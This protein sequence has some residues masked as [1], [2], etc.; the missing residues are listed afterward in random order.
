MS[1]ALANRTR[2]AS[3][4]RLR[5]G[6]RAKKVLLI[7]CAVSLAPLLPLAVLRFVPPPITP[8]MIIRAHDGYRIERQWVS[9]RAI[10]QPLRRAAI[11]AE[12]N[13]FC[14]ETSGIDFDALDQAVGVWFEG[15]RPH[16]ASTITMQTARNL[17]LWPGR[18]Y[19]RKLIELWITPQ[20]AI[21]WP[22]QR[23][24]E[25]YLNI[26]EFGPAIFGVQAAARHYFGKDASQLSVIEATRLIAVLPD[27]LHR[28]PATLAPH[29]LRGAQLA[30]LPVFEG[31]S[32]FEC[33][34]P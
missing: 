15:K 21:L 14:E 9:L 11:Y 20:I 28:T 4:S 1:A 33:G 26:A 25:V 2:I 31:D 3:I 16:G 23:V 5:A 34:N 29:V 27:P 13:R 30:T 22:R 10:A 7:A 17:F 18:S 32:E 24:L 19:L 6:P 8:L 12:D